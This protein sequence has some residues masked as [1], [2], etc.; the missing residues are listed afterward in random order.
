MSFRKFRA[1][2]LAVAMT[3]P[4]ILTSCDSSNP[5]KK[6]GGAKKETPLIWEVTLPDSDTTLYLFGSIHAGT[7][8]L[9]PLNDKI[10]DAYEDSDYLAVECDIVAFEEDIAAQMNMSQSMMYQDGSTIEDHL[11][12]ETFAKVKKYLEDTDSYYS[13]YV[14]FK[15]AMFESLLSL[16]AVEKSGMSADY[17]IDKFFINEATEDGKEIIEVESIE[18]QMQMLANFP[19]GYYDFSLS[20]AVDSLREDDDPMGKLYKAWRKGDMAYFET[21]LTDEYDELTDEQIGYLEEYNKA[22]LTDRNKLMSEAA[23]E[24]FKD[25][26]N[27][28]YVVGLAHMIGEDGIVALLEDMG[29]TVTR[30]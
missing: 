7:K 30:I 24:I 19:D 13:M 10:M 29:Y 11:S 8:D 3:V 18:S 20:M 26:K 4:L 9:F 5:N 28:F 23:D 25:G 2:L 12:A 15:P 14:F 21:E 27:C 16:D 6:T 17:G 1:A 22:M